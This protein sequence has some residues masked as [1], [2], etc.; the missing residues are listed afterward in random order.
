MQALVLINTPH[1]SVFLISFCRG[2]FDLIL[3]L[4]FSETQDT[5]HVGL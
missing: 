4:L 3:N 2:W 1:I 5:H